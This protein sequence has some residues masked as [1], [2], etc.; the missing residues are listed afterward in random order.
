[1]EDIQDSSASDDEYYQRLHDAN[2]LIVENYASNILSDSITEEEY[3]N[4]MSDE[5]SRN[6]DSYQEEANYVWK[7][8]QHDTYSLKSVQMED[9][10]HKIVISNM[11]EFLFHHLP[12]SSMAYVMM[13]RKTGYQTWTD[14]YQHPNLLVF[15]KDVHIFKDLVVFSTYSTLNSSIVENILNLLDNPINLSL[16]CVNP[17]YVDLLCDVLHKYE[18]D[19]RPVKNSVLLVN[20]DASELVLSPL[21]AG[22][23]YSDLRID[24]AEVVDFYWPYHYEGSVFMIRE[25]ISTLPCVGIRTLDTNILVSW[26]LTYDYGALAMLHTLT[27][28][29]RL[30][31]ANATVRALLQRWRSVEWGCAPF[32]F[33]VASN[34]ASIDLLSSLGF[35]KRADVCWMFCSKNQKLVT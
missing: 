10:Y 32:A 23:Y 16:Q 15:T 9:I 33:V 24:D 17:L 30:K 11:S 3:Y 21:P 26:C 28:H 25:M 1:M 14:S 8:V 27:E 22:Y 18:Y 31:L 20:E 7:E 4:R 5:G 35:V 29:R 34:Q 6:T 13:N 2:C 19:I 12:C